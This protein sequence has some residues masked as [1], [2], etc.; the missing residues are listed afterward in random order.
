METNNKTAI[1]HLLVRSRQGIVFEGDVKSLSSYNDEGKFDIL[2]QHAN[3]ISLIQKSLVIYDMN[4]NVKELNL[5]NALLR[6]RGNYVEVYLG[7]GR[8]QNY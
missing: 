6:N 7:V 8:N 2:A 4:N 3:F 5:E 1:F